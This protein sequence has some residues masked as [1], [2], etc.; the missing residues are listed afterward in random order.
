MAEIEAFPIENDERPIGWEGNAT[1]TALAAAAVTQGATLRQAIKDAKEAY[2]EVIHRAII[3]IDA[4]IERGVQY[5]DLPPIPK[6][7]AGDCIVFT[8]QEILTRIRDFDTTR[9][10][11][12]IFEISRP[13]PPSFLLF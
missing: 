6:F 5:S 9:S 2:I 12:V 7:A 8:Q 11:T 13:V 1:T 4:M 3:E 10:Y